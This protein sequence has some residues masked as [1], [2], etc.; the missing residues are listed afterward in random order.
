MMRKNIL[1]IIPNL[2]TGGAQKVFRQQLSFLSSHYVVHACVFNWDGAFEDD[3][4]GNLHS[5]NVP[6]GRNTF[7]K[8]WNFLL[9][10]VRLRTLKRKLQIDVSISHL[11]GADY[12][13]VLSRSRDK[14]ICWI[15]GTK[16]FD[17]NIEGK[18]GWLRKKVLIPILTNRSDRIVTVSEAIKHELVKVY[19]MEP[20]RIVTIYNGFDTGQ[21]IQQKQELLPERFSFLAKDAAIITH[22]RLSRQKNLFAL[23][24]IHARVCRRTKYPLI[25]LGDGELRDELVRFSHSLKMKTFNIWSDMTATPEYDVFFLGYQS[26]P[27]RFLSMASMYVMTSGWEGFPL[28]LCEALACGVTVMSTDCPTGPREILHPSMSISAEPVSEMVYGDYGLLMPLANAEKEEVLD[29]WAENVN[30]VMHDPGLL[31]QYAAAGPVRVKEFEI[32][33]TIREVV[34]V[35]NNL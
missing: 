25:I 17:E 7:L 32:K 16:E 9:R 1:V 27:Y 24:Q 6:A 22:C 34:Q 35:I 2:G 8:A 14:V 29:Y 30:R 26:N 5:L 23:L 11:E 33:N 3:K 15:H 18:T 12:V 10:I 31:A 21:I 28:A 20:Q 4:K 19:A 13:N